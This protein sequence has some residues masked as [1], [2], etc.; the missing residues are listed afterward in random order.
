MKKHDIRT[1]AAAFITAV[2]LTPFLGWT[3][4][5]ESGVPLLMMDSFGG[6]AMAMNDVFCGIADD[7]NTISVN[8]AGLGALPTPQVSAM[9]MIFPQGM[10]FG[11]L[12]AGLPAGSAG[13]AA[14]SV[15]YYSLAEFAELDRLG[16]ET[17]EQLS[18]SD[19]AVTAA[20][21]RRLLSADV[22]L[23][24]G[25]A[26]KFISTSLAGSALSGFAADAGVV[27]RLSAPGQIKSASVPL[28]RPKAT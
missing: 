11:H 22:G 9:Y 26:V 17:G 6:R 7:I 19:I 16:A 23:D 20:F 8:P 25:L 2:L 27:L 24:A 3:A 1:L 10:S 13:Y 14:L 18:A 15:G 4:T 12:A 28:V 5:G 21:G